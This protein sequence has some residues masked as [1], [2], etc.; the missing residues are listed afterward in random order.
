MTAVPETTPAGWTF[1]NLSATMVQVTASEQDWRRL[2]TYV[3]RR[4]T[5][6]G[7]TQSQVQ[8]RGGPSVA[9][10]RNIE[11][12]IQDRYRDSA[13]RSL[14]RVL[15]WPSGAVDRI[16][17]GGEPKEA[18]PTAGFAY[19]GDDQL[20]A[21]EALLRAIRDNPNRSAPLRAMAAAQLDQLAAIRAA[22]EAEEEQRRTEAS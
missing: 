8:A 20:A 10:V 6:L 19:P 17:A 4:R 14:E 18:A 7:L 22:D 5:E 2:G 9:T 12:A 1:Q 15:D 16:L 13:L 3:T 11:R 21:A